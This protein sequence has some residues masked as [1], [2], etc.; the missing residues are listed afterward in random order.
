[1]TDLQ[2]LK[3]TLPPDL[4]AYVQEAAARTDRTPSG[5]VRHWISEQKRREPPPEAT[6]VFANSIT[7]APVALTP[8]GVVEGRARIVSLEREI[9]KRRA[10]QQRHADVAGD[11]DRIGEILLE[12]DIIRKGID[13]ATRMM[14][15]NNRGPNDV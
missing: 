8:A 11:E 5:M 7:V 6:P 2:Q 12:I 10:R 3:I 4:L 14:R 15:P 1:M 13:M 9:E